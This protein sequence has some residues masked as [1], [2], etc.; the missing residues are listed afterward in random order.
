VNIFFL[1]RNSKTCAQF[2]CDRHVVKMILESAQMLCNTH[3]F[4]N[5]N[6]P[7]L[8]KK[9]HMNHPSSVWIRKSKKHYEWLYSLF[10]ELSDEYK[11]RY[12][13]IHKTDKK[14]RKVLKKLPVGIP[15]NGFEDPP[16]A[17]PEQYHS[18]NAV[19]SYRDY[20]NGEKYSF[21]TW[22]KR[23]IPNWFGGK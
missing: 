23:E 2:H 12:G 14:L 4:F 16:L 21:C 6:L 10:C 7:N 18:E 5:S 13:K 22:R 8:Y 1:D 20:Y 17:M 9:T 11:Y 19:K 3:H 15:D